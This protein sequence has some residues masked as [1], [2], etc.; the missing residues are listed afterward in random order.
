M[1]PINAVAQFKR[2]TA[3]RDASCYRLPDE[4]A[5]AQKGEI[6]VHG[7]AFLVFAVAIGVTGETRLLRGK[8]PRLTN[9][10]ARPRLFVPRR[11]WASLIGTALGCAAAWQDSLAGRSAEPSAFE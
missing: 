10:V 11:L 7:E 6:P 8:R 3:E 4:I 2:E 5:L 1:G 9:A